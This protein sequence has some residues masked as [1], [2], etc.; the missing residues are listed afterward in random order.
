MDFNS[1]ISDVLSSLIMVVKRFF[2]L[3]VQPYK[4]LRKIS[5]EEDYLQIIFIIFFIFIYFQLAHQIKNFA[6]S[7]VFIFLIFFIQFVLSI[8]FF[9]FLTSISSKEVSLKS[10]FF[11]F[12]YSLLPTLIWFITNS[13]LYVLF[14]PPRTPS[15]LGI[16]FSLIFISFSIGLLLWKIILTYLAIRFSSKLPFYRIIY[17]IILYLCVLSPYIIVLYKLKIFRVP[18]I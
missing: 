15:A 1:I 2:L 12:T 4:T 17:A 13:L 16:I 10:Y 7:P 5:L 18:F 9:Y 8:F 6:F 14:P 11:T 3:I